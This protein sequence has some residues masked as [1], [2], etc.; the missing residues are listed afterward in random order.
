MAEREYKESENMRDEV[1][2]EIRKEKEE[3]FKKSQ[4][5]FQH[6]AQ[7][8]NLIGDISGTLSASRNLQANLTKLELEKNRQQELLYNADF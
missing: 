6:R 2:K 7:Q 5:L 8:A 3:L 4:E 1:E